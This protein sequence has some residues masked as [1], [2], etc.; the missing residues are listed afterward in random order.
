MPAAPQAAQPP[1]AG[2]PDSL[3]G[4]QPFI[5]PNSQMAGQLANHP[6]SEQPEA[7]D[8]QAV[9]PE[10]Q[11]QY[12]DLVTRAKLFINDPRKPINSKGQPIPGA[13]APRDVIVDH[14]NLPGQTAAD[15]V[16]RTTAQVAWILYTNAKRQGYAYP[17]DV[18]YH[19]ADEILSDL[20]HIALAA[21]LIK[22]PPARGS[23]EEEHFLGV[24]KLAACKFF[25]QNLIDTGQANSKEAQ[26]YYLAQIKREGESGALDNWDPSKQF[27]PAEL[28]AF[29]AKA[30]AGKA[31]VK[32]R[33][34]PPTTISDFADRG[35]PQLVPP[36]GAA[37]P[38]D[39]SAP[40]PD[41]QA[42]AAAAG[43]P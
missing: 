5:P 34:P 31:Q 29:M 17:P 12:D 36:G 38:Q 23:V 22:N 41:D 30:A 9:T 26:E 39:Q 11:K 4:G 3:T 42:A 1:D 25:G 28:N 15:S 8:D 27:T 19:G 32:G 2:Q 40:S 43:G 13:K 33:P 10:E 14:L 6:V 21:N 24:A 20:Y 16:G 35:H 18:L 37:P 7:E